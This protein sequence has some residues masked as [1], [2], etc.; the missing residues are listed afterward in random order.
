MYCWRILV[1]E[2]ELLNVSSH[3]I[4]CIQLVYS[5]GNSLALSNF[6]FFSSLL[7]F[8][9]P[10]LG[11]EKPVYIT[12]AEQPTSTSSICSVEHCTTELTISANV[13]QHRYFKQSWHGDSYRASDFVGSGWKGEHFE[14]SCSTL[15][16]SLVLSP[17]F[18]SWSL[19]RHIPGH[20]W[21]SLYDLLIGRPMVFIP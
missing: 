11:E 14:Q 9:L 3:W 21:P 10:G 17:P 1:R 4:F 15:I 8:T 19:S 6:V 5:S 7:Q 20:I 16:L 13:F 2:S 18:F 12:C